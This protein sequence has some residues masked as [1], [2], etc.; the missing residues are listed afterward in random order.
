MIM[1]GPN[2]RIELRKVGKIHNSLRLIVPPVFIKNLN[3]KSGNYFS[4]GIKQ[5]KGGN[6]IVLRKQKMK[7]H[8]KSDST[9][10]IKSSDE[11][12]DITVRKIGRSGK[13]LYIT[14]PYNI[15]NKVD[16]KA[17]DYCEISQLEEDTINIR[18]HVIQ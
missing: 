2:G 12:S 5:E 3:I 9:E 17:Q 18:K 13:S 4:M 7:S 1:N 16:I 8:E 6:I 10:K 15:A 14:I 11:L